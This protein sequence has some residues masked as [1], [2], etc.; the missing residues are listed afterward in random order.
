MDISRYLPGIEEVIVGGESGD[1]ARVYDFRW[2][3]NL[4]RQCRKAHTPFHFKKAL[5]IA[6]WWNRHQN[7]FMTLCCGGFPFPGREESFLP[8]TKRRI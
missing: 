6:G 2:A 4:H 1:D 7:G 5:A 3:L 8:D